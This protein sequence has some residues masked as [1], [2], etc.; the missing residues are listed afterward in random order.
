MICT[1]SFGKNKDSA[2]CLFVMEVDELK[3][4]EAMVIDDFVREV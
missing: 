2:A 1:T 4:S 3:E